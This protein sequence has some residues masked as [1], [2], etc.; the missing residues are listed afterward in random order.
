MT[1]T[2]RTSLGSA[3]FLALLV[4]VAIPAAAL[5]GAKQQ[6]PATNDLSASFRAANLGI[7]DLRVVEVGGIVVIRGRAASKAN[8]E[9]ASKMARDLGYERVANLVQIIEPPDDDAIE[10]RAERALA[11]QRS[12]DG[13]NFRLDSSNGSLLVAGT[14]KYE[15]QKDMAVH[16][17][18]GVDGVRTVKSDLH[19]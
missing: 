10:R 16:V 9:A 17:L 1:R 2:I 15:L 19:Q 11:S 5:A 3:F 18:R 13:C 4:A 8:A 6:K 14:V 7:D 12:L